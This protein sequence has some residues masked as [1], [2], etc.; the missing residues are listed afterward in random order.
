MQ[1]IFPV[2]M[3]GG[4]GS[5]LWPVSNAQRPKQFHSLAEPKTMIQATAARF[6]GAMGGAMFLDPMIVAGAAHRAM[7]DE[8]MAAIGVKPQAIVLE[9]MG[10]NTAATALL[11]AETAQALD[12]EALVLLLPA[13]HVIAKPEAFLEAILRSA[14]IA[15]SRIVTFGITPSG[16]ETGYGYIQRGAALTEGVFEIARFREKPTQD[17]AQTLIE[18]G[19]HVWN[20][21]IFLFSPAVAIQEFDHAPEVRVC[22]RAALAEAVRDGIYTHLPEAIFAETPSLPFDIAVMER[23]RL[24][25]VAPC[26]MGWADVGSW[27][28]LWKISPQDARGNAVFGQT[29]LLDS[30]NCLVFSEGPPIAIA[31]L[32][33]MIVVATAA[34]TLVVPMDRAQDVKALL[35]RLQA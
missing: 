10:R 15:H 8:Q 5:R 6:R 13:D 30:D 9:P 27:S 3:S 31:G 4:A 35:A 25:A 29:A 20:A 28:E 11:A 32:S 34:G 7:I 17:L 2:L 24:S 12:P 16:P 23:T 1:K 33:N 22:V 14:A 19:R 18:D 26:D 21:G